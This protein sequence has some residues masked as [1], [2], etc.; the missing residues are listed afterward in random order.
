MSNNWFTD[1]C[2]T[3]VGTDGR[4]LTG[5][6]RDAAER[7][8]QAAKIANHKIWTD[9]SGNYYHRERRLFASSKRLVDE[10]GNP[11]RI[12]GKRVKKAAKFC[13]SCGSSSTRV[14]FSNSSVIA[15]T[16]IMSTL[17]FCKNPVF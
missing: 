16:Y 9:R 12:C 2:T 11:V 13:S 8:L 10:L 4:A 6:A 7:A 17:W 14:D 3:L 15:F 1:V 5:A